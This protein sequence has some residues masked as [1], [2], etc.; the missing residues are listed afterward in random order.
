[1][2]LRWGGATFYYSAFF[3]P[4]LSLSILFY[5]FLS[6]SSSSIDAPSV[7]WATFP[8]SIS[9]KRPCIDIQGGPTF[10]FS[11]F[12]HP[13]LCFSSCMLRRWGGSTFP[14]SSTSIER[15]RIDIRWGGATFYSSALFYHFPLLCSFGGVGGIFL[16]PLLLQALRD[17]ALISGCWGNFFLFY[18][19]LSF[20]MLFLFYAPS[21][22]WATFPS[23]TSIKRPCIDIR[24]W[25]N[26]FLF[27]PFP[28]FSSCMLLRWGGSTFS[29]SS[30]SIRR[31]RID[32]WGVGK[33]F[34]LL[35][36]ALGDLLH[37]H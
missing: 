27:Y 2:L 22:G 21:V 24:G 13:F 17:L 6:F 10:S 28:S 8:S 35:L 36:Q 30:T 37:S 15:P 33:L 7:G 34:P 19:F 12:F 31:P 4:F 16:F 26:F 1:M 11:I 32:I 20:S 5:A 9:I 3:H 25:A 14:S 23:S 29:S 18:P